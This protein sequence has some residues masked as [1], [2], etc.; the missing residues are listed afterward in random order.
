MELLKRKYDA[1]EVSQQSP[2]YLEQRKCLKASLVMRRR[3]ALLGKMVDLKPSE[4]EDV[5]A[6]KAFW[7]QIQKR[8]KMAAE[9][10]DD[11]FPVDFHI[12]EIKCPENCGLLP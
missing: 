7:E 1:K 3:L 10:A 4:G 12:Y 5:E 11:I 8:E 9:I 6:L 2:N